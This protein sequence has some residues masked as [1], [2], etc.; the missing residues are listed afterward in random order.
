[1]PRQPG[2]KHLWHDPRAVLGLRG[3]LDEAQGG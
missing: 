1:M 2:K 3:E